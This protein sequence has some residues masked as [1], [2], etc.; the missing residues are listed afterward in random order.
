MPRKFIFGL[1][2]LVD[3]RKQVEEAA[4]RVV[5]MRRSERDEAQRE[6]DR[7]EAQLRV[8]ASLLREQ[9][10]ELPVSELAVRYD[11]LQTLER[12]IAAQRVLLSK[13]GETLEDACQ[14]LATASKK[15]TVVEKL[16]G[17]HEARAIAAEIRAEE[18]EIDESNASG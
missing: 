14:D 13:C 6:L 3:R 15:R 16:K 17:R 4:Q 7:L 10:R 8:H 11:H 5:A 12:A 18:A 2:P 9:Q 1:Q